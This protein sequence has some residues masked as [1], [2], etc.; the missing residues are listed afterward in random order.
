MSA[1]SIAPGMAF[2]KL[3]EQDIP[4]SQVLFIRG[5][6][7]IAGLGIILGPM[8]RLNR[9]NL[10]VKNPFLFILKAVLW[11]IG[12]I[13]FF[14]A[15]SLADL[16]ILNAVLMVG[17]LVTMVLARVFLGERVTRPQQ[18]GVAV[19]FM[20]VLACVL[21]SFEGSEGALLVGIAL[22]VLRMVVH[23][24]SGVISRYMAQRETM[25]VYMI[26]ANLI[27]IPI[28]LIGLMVEDWIMLD[29]RSSICLLGFGILQILVTFLNVLTLQRLPAAVASAM[30]YIQLPAAVVVALVLF[31]EIPGPWFYAGSI[32]LI[33]GLCLAT[34]LWRP[35]YLPVTSNHA[36]KPDGVGGATVVDKIT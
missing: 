1:L 26:L 11:S 15:I 30:S 16:A 19:A 18:V 22:A 9:R 2:L 27:S 31:S 34:G 32:T 12:S 8:G 35:K 28:A 6:L 21:P 13:A 5:A 10:Q 7:V 3:I 24:S 14:K 33:A 23:A 4:A 36:G 25:E 20:G 17:P 29:V